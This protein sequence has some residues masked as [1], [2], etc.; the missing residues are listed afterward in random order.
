MLVNEPNVLLHAL[1]A[2]INFVHTGQEYQNGNSLAA[3]GKVLKEHRQRVILAIKERPA[4]LDQIL[5]VLNTDYVDIVMP[6]I[7][8]VSALKDNRLEEEFQIAKQAGKCRYLGFAC[9]SEM[10]PVL[11]KAAGMNIFDVAMV[12]YMNTEDPWFFRSLRLARQAGMGI[13]AMRSIPVRT[14]RSED[15]DMQALARERYSNILNRWYAHSIMTS[16]GSYQAVDS[17]SRVL[18]DSIVWNNSRTPN[19]G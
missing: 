19:R 16:M 1:D 15:I 18:E 8:S 2:G 7:H 3:F 5:R 11:E 10:T 4:N 12:N 9:H 17:Y 14:Y 13:V 6:P